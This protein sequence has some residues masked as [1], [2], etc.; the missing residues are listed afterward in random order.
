MPFKLRY[1]VNVD[2]VGAGAGPMEALSPAIQ[3]SGGG[4]TGQTKE[5]VTSVTA[6]PIALGA[7]SGQTLTA[8]DVTNLTN[9]MATDIAAQI[10]AA[11]TTI[12]AW[13]TGGP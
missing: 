1:S 3:S 9:A 8:G 13:P 5:F 6:I 7:G 4:S 2:F 11:L 10:N 12:N